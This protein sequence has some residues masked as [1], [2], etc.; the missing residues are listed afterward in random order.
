MF[1]DELAGNPAKKR[2]DEA[3]ARR[4]RA[5]R[6]KEEKEAR[7]RKELERRQREEAASAA[8]CSEYDGGTN[9]IPMPSS[10]VSSPVVGG[11]E[12]SW[13]AP[14]SPD[15]DVP[16]NAAQ[17]AAEQRKIRAEARAKLSAATT[18]QSCVRSKLTASKV[19]EQ[20]RAIWDKRMSDLIA[21]KAILKRSSAQEYIAPPATVSIMATQFLFFAC[22]TTIRKNQSSG[23]VFFEDRSFILEERD[24]SRWSKFVKHLIV[25]GIVSDSNLDLDPFIPWVESANGRKRLDYVLTLLISSV[26]RRQMKAKKP[27][28]ATDKGNNV[29]HDS[30]ELLAVVDLVLRNLL[31]LKITPAYSGGNRDIIHQKACSLLIRS[32]APSYSNY[33]QP[34]SASVKMEHHTYNKFTPDLISSLRSLIL[35][36]SNGSSE[37]IPPDSERTREACSAKD[38]KCRAD[39]LA[40]LIIDFIISMESGSDQ[41]KRGRLCS[42]FVSEILTVPLFTWKVNFPSYA[43]LI[44]NQGL[45]SPTLVDYIRHFTNTFAND[46]SDGRIAA[47]L[48]KSDISLNTCPAPPVLCLLS[49]MI[50]IGNKCDAING[51]SASKLHYKAAA[52]YYNFVATLINVAPLGTFSSKMSAVEW[53]SNGS[54]SSPIVLS[55]VVIEQAT[56]FLSDSNVRSLFNCAI[57]DDV[58]MTNKVI[59]TK[60]EKDVKQENDLTEIGSTSATSLAAK[61]AMVDRN[62][63]FWQSSKWAKKLTQFISSAGE[64][65]TVSESLTSCPKDS[66]AGEGQLMNTSS[67]SR[68]LANGKGSISRA[69][70][71]SDS[72]KAATTKPQHEYCVSFFFAL[73]RAY[74]TIISR[75]GGNGKEDLVRRISSKAR[76]IEIESASAKLEPCVSALLNVLCFSTN[77][78]SSSWAIVQSNSKVVSDLYCVIDVNKGPVPIRALACHNAQGANEGN[79]GASVLLMFV[80]CLSHTLIV[81][82]DV[83]LHEME[84]PLP[85]HQVR[86]CILL[87]KK[88]L[89]RACCL[90]DVHSSTKNGQNTLP[91]NHLGL[92]LISVSSKVMNDLYSRSS[93]RLL[94]VPKLWIEEDLLEQDIRRCKSHLDYTSLLSSPVCRICPFLVS[95]KRRLKLF[96]R[97]VTT[98]RNDI[99]GSNEQRNL[100]PGIMVRVQRGRV[101][102]DGLIHLNNLGRN[103]RQRICV[104]Y[105]SDVGTR[106]SGVDV[107]GLFKEFWTD[108]SALAFDPNYALFKVTEE[109]L[110]YPNPSSKLAHGD[111]SIKLFEFLGRILGKALYEGITIQP[112]FAHLFLSFLRG[113]HNYLHLLTDLSTIDK[114]L[115]N[116]LMFL[117]TYEGDAS[118]LC[119]TFTVANDDFGVNEQNLIPNGSDIEVTNANKRRYIYLVAKH[120]VC[121]RIKEQSDAFTRGLWEVIDRSW[122][123]LFNEP[124]LQV[125]IS[126]AS[127]GKIDVADMKSNSKYSGGYTPLDRNIIRFWNVVSS[128]TPKQQADLLRFVTSCERPPPLGFSS[129]NPPFTIQRVGIMRDGDKLPSAST[130]FNTL[131][132]PTYSSEKV[133]KERLV[134]AIESKAGF[135]LT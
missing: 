102:E 131:K 81:T 21:L 105:I 64:K 92:A 56:V 121:D 91:S 20:Q 106:E 69:L 124:E 32:S 99:Q 73:C 65:M 34:K 9:D 101:L 60:T 44:Q 51:T 77:I 104:N 86:R 79:I 71:N 35:F 16:L 85:K 116:N 112:Q 110:M 129:M 125:L 97:I 90:D 94:C 93:R 31:R 88:L 1:T 12:K 70:T 28:G 128:F 89:Y 4:I 37:P 63:R 52:E 7:K 83:E 109:S 95:F 80:A 74:G 114:Q 120:H 41:L 19:M 107:G 18:I 2:A 76:E 98:N 30:S 26:A 122:L 123:R 82:D 135:E 72:A 133:L 14:N 54:I 43:S 40:K 132:L 68:Q 111:M 48:N 55:N 42:R 58:L 127:D 113:D 33:F 66:K 36:G 126:G 15:A 119:L 6:E 11:G 59:D 38:E 25:P 61:E 67:L 96:E 8:A 62:R 47:A 3:K 24:L 53:V 103:M 108:L 130:C 115:Y 46:V 87:L 117:K 22:P 49:N 134:Y 84:K 5:K 57:D 29:G 13:N 75:W 100:K 10:D 17:K 23:E 27:F 50:Q 39:V 118:D 78:L 45:K